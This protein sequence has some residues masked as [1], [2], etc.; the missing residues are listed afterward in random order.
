M[1]EHLAGISRQVTP[2]THAVLAL[3]GAGWHQPGGKLR[4]PD[5]LGLL[6]LPPCSRELNPVEAVWRFL[7][8]NRLGNRACDTC[9]AIVDACGS[10]WNAPRAR[11]RCRGRAQARIHPAGRVDGRSGAGG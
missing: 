7:R 6:P 8:Q 4:I 1:N 5:D 9:D 11:R 10:A 3:D 2:G